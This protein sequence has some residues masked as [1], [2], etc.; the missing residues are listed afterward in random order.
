MKYILMCAAALAVCIGCAWFPARWIGKK[1]HLK[2]TA[3]LALALVFCLVLILAVTFGY[4]GMYY[5]AEPTEGS[6]AVKMETIDG[7]CL[8]DGPGQDYALIFYPGA[9]VE[10][11]AYAP[12]MNALA[13]RGV[14]CF[15]ADM[16][17]RMAIFGSS[18]GDRFLD[19][20]TYPHWAAAGHSMGGLVI[21]GWAADH[22]DR[23]ENL[24]LLAAYPGSTIPD[25]IHLCSI[26]GTQDGCLNRSA[27]NDAMQFW[28]VQSVEY[29]IEG[30]NHA[31]YA[32]YGPQSGDLEPGITR[33]EQQDSTVRLILEAIGCI[34][35]QAR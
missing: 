26:Y 2:R 28:P 30:G 24:I 14:D 18:I 27:Y 7:G 4:L 34:E 25:S 15:L 5:H 32:N 9:K 12:L 35:S 6:P 19:A 1:K 16:P 17:F 11:L 8:F 29:A 13:Q 23:I 31:Q 33:Q 3:V 22:A 21:S 20:Y 10:A